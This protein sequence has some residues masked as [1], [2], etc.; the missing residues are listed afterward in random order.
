[1]TS[2]PEVVEQILRPVRTALAAGESLHKFCERNEVSYTALYNLLHG[3]GTPRYDT[4]LRLHARLSRP[5][6]PPHLPL[7]PDL[8]LTASAE[9]WLGQTRCSL[10]GLGR[11]TAV[12]GRPGSGV[13]TLLSLLDMLFDPFGGMVRAEQA[14]VRVAPPGVP[15]RIEAHTP[16]TTLALTLEGPTSGPCAGATHLT[17]GTTQ[18]VEP[19]HEATVE[20]WFWPGHSYVRSG[21]VARVDLH[22]VTQPVDEVLMREVVQHKHARDLLRAVGAP[23]D[24]RLPRGDAARLVSHV[25]VAVHQAPPLLLLDGLDKALEGHATNLM[26]RVLGDAI[27]A[28]LLQQVVLGARWGSHLLGKVMELQGTVLQVRRAQTITGEIEAAP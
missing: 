6:V 24:G 25:L 8:L 2:L 22:S 20:Q 19:Y 21:R 23:C 1:M 14:G 4:M 5:T 7:V 12:A 15:V 11:L 9:P 26:A 3:R 18:Q 16:S 27:Q 28:G 10:R 13:T 17:Y